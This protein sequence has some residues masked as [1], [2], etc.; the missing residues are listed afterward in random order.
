MSQDGVKVRV[1]GH[2]E[3]LIVPPTSEDLLVQSGCHPDLT[4]MDDVPPER[5]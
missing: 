5:A 1:E 3:P 4:D 2:H